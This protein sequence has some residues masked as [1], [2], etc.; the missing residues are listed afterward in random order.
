MYSCRRL[1]EL[2]ALAERLSEMQAYHAGSNHE[3]SGCLLAT[4]A[5]WGGGTARSRVSKP[6][7]VAVHRF[8]AACH[9]SLALRYGLLF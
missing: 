2:L 8:S 7:C 3:R 6:R 4:H 5:Q 9:A 1:S